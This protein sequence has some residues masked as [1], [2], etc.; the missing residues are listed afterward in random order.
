MRSHHRRKAVPALAEDDLSSNCLA[1]NLDNSK[2]AATAARPQG[3]ISRSRA[4]YA[5]YCADAA[6]NDPAQSAKYH[7]WVRGWRRGR[8]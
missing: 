2:Y 5:R 6:L 3:Q 7:A 1:G 4:D 8:K